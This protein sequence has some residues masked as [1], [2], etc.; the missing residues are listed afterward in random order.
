MLRVRG[1]RS[2]AGTQELRPE[3][4]S[5]TFP[6]EEPPSRRLK[7]TLGYRGT[8]YAGW[9]T[10]PA[11]RTAGR[12]TVQDT[13]EAALSAVLGHPV[14]VT[15]A[16]RTD[17]GVHADAQVVS[18]DT[19][20][21]IPVESLARVLDGRLPDDLWVVALEDAE[22]GFDARRSA[23]RRWYRYAV[24]R[25]HFPPP[26]WRGRCLV[27]PEPLDLSAMRSASRPLLG[28]RN[29][30]SLVGGWGRDAR[31]GKS[32]VRTVFAADWIEPDDSPLL[33][34]EVGGDAFL[35]QMVRTIVGSLLWVGEGRWEPEAFEAALASADRRAAGPAAPPQGL[36]LWK[37]EYDEVH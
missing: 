17:A 36:T 2:S 25:A 1:E 31:P 7:L 37:I 5:R 13:L 23:T 16:G 21:T 10:Q 6:I 14:R 27:H 11:D 19:T 24:W 22:R 20:S 33:L 12:P 18:F 9:A 32:T 26:C 30:A 15:A 28:R 8:R 29:M 34:F 4:R 35:R 3:T